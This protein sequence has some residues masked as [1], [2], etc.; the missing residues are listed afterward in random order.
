MWT[1]HGQT[2]PQAAG[3]NE[4]IRKFCMMI[5]RKDGGHWAGNVREVTKPEILSD[6][7]ECGCDRQLWVG[8]GQWAQG[9]FLG[10]Q[11]AGHK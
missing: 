5:L 11:K 3:N 2:G 8:H 4:L 6:A 1:W 7:G 9:Q 10:W